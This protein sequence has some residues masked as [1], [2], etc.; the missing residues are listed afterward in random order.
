[1]VGFKRILRRWFKRRKKNSLMPGV[2]PS[3]LSSESCMPDEHPLSSLP[4][5]RYWHHERRVSVQGLPPPGVPHWLRRFDWCIGWDHGWADVN[6]PPRSVFCRP[7]ALED[8]LD[9]LRAHKASLPDEAFLVCGGE[10]FRL[11]DQKRRVIRGLGRLFRNIYYEAMDVD[12]PNVKMMPI[13]LTEFYARGFESEIAFTRQMPHRKTSLIVAAFGAFWPQL[14]SRLADRKAAVEFAK[15]ASF[16]TKGPFEQSVYFDELAK[17]RYMI[18]PQGQGVQAPK[19]L[20]AFMTM[21]IPVLTDSPMAR[22]WANKGAPVLIVNRWSDVSESLLM[23]ELSGLQEQS[24]SFHEVVTDADKYWN[25]SF[26]E[27]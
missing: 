3:H 9:Y 18:C 25:F 15:S 19:I 6:I 20:E 12:L 10:D 24:I 21:T 14:N 4:C 1:M 17:H 23:S 27:N 26:G 2:L 22:S 11:G 5:T 7:S 8:L 13:G 16:V